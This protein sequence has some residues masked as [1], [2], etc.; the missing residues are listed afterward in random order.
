ME[1]TK[2]IASLFQMLAQSGDYYEG[3]LEDIQKVLCMQSSS[4]LTTYD[5]RRSHCN[6]K[7]ETL[8]SSEGASIYS[9][10]R[11]LG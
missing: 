1:K 5:V 11:L 6:N 2:P 10:G 9:I 8:S 3:F 4:T 7:I